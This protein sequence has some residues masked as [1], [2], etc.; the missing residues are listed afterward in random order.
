MERLC[1]LFFELSNQ[2]RLRILLQ[3][4]KKA[5]NVTNLSKKLSLTKQEVSRHVS[6]MSEAGLT[7]KN[8]DGSHVLTMY[9]K[10]IL[11][12]TEGLEF[13]SKRR[14]YF[15]SHSLTQLPQEYVSRIGDLVNSTYS[16]D[17]S[18][19]FYRIEKMIQEADEYIFTIT[20]KYL[21]DTNF[22]LGEACGR[23]VKVENI[24]ARDWAIDLE[25]FQA[26][27]A[28]DVKRKAI[29]Q[30][31]IS[32]ILQERVLDR[33]DAY[34]YM[35]EKGVAVLGFPL[36]DGKFDHV[37]FFASD[38]R[39]HAWC[40]DLFQYYWERAEPREHILEGLY[41]WIK[42]RPKT[43]RA[44]KA[45]VEGKQVREEK[46]VAELEKK[47]LMNQGR[48]TILALFLLQRI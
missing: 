32:R 39:A 38:R 40:R 11:K 48:L 5:M 43:V 34:L 14:N 37:G 33:L 47:G 13:T 1:D 12:Q 3:L 25:F 15:T 24:E 6:R 42:K 19:V 22:Q 26:Y 46:M 27:M 30:A 35:S 16:D 18:A 36:S 7:K 17:I 45:I 2:D 23:G 44:L 10:V 29:S 41:T 4:N 21:F 8:V 9:G 20:D 28:E 31:R